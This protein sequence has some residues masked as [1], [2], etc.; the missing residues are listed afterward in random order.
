M[1]IPGAGASTGKTFFDATDF[2]G[3]MP[4][5]SVTIAAGTTVS[6][7]AIDVPASAIGTA[8]DKWLMISVTAPGGNPIYDPTAQ[9]DILNS[10]TEA[11]PPPL[12]T[13]Q[14]PR[15]MA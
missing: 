8:T 13:R 14:P 11:C 9:T 3:T 4:F 2:G 12:P 7:A 6:P 5:G 15:P 1:A 10:A